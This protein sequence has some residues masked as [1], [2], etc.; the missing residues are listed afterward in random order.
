[1]DRLSSQMDRKARREIK[2]GLSSV[3]AVVLG[4]PSLTLAQADS[5][6]VDSI[7]PYPSLRVRSFAEV[8]GLDSLWSDSVWVWNGTC[9]GPLRSFRFEFPDS[10]FS[11]LEFPCTLQANAPSDLNAP[12]TSSS[13]ASPLQVWTAAVSISL[14]DLQAMSRTPLA[15]SCFPPASS[16]AFEALLSAME[17]AVFETEKCAVLERAS[18]TLCLTR[19]QMR[20]ALDRIASEDRKLETLERIT[21]SDIEWA[22][23][24]LRELFQLNFILERALKRFTKR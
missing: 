16:K 4:L 13:D 24:E 15:A 17:Q 9:E 20:Q 23:A 19:S 21:R 18:Q 5:S 22:E 2:V 6:L 10:T 1:M 12:L 8:H 3:I 7:V 11:A 14:V